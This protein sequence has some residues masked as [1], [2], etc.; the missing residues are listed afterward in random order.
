MIDRILIQTTLQQWN[1]P[2]SPTQLDLLEHYSALLIEWNAQMNLVASST[3]AEL[4]RRH[5][6]DSLAIAT[7]LPSAP[8]SLADVGSGAGL[9]GLPLAIIW[10]ASQVTLIESI[11]K[12]SHFLRHVVATLPLPNVQV[13]TDR[14]EALGLSPQHRER[15]AL[16][17][18]RAVANLATLAEF[19][20]PLCAVGGTWLAPKG[21]DVSAE[22]DD[23]ALAI[24]LLG[25]AIEGVYDVIIPDEPTRALI[26]VTKQRATPADY[27][28]AVGLPA[29]NPL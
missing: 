17:T 16:V 14:A 6:L 9:P 8:A 26:V 10:P 28:R 11:G 20:L 15:Y 19:C 4:T 27:P 7:A 23:A 12:K 18:A 21:P 25:G 2:C 3:L 1:I 29:K 13:I 22:V 24:D 5:L